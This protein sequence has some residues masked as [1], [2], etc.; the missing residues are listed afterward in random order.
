MTA[1]DPGTSTG[2]SGAWVRDRLGV[3]VRTTSS[4]VGLDLHDLVGLAVRRNP[5]R[6]H[7]LVS[8]VL[9]KHVPTDPRV[10]HGA[11]LLL[12]LLVRHA[13]AGD[14]LA[15]TARHHGDRL[16]AALADHD[17]A[18]AFRDAVVA[19]LDTDVPHGPPPVV[20]GYA[21][22]AVALGFSVAAA[23]P[24]STALHST[25]R[26]VVGY[27]AAGGFEEEHSHATSHLLLPADPDLLT[28]D[29]PRPLVL[30]DDELSTGTTVANTIAALHRLCPRDRYVVAA[31]VDLRGADDE[32]RLR[33]AVEGLG[34]RL[35]VVALARGE[36][37]LPAGVLERGAA[38]VEEV[39]G[40]A[41]AAP[42]A[43]SWTTAPREVPVVWP[44][45]Q[46]EGARHGLAWEQ[47]TGLE[48]AAAALATRIAVRGGEVHVLGTEEQ[49]AAPLLLGCALADAHPDV[50]V[51]YSTTTRSPALAVDDPGCALRT[52]LAFTGPEDGGARFAY[53]TPAAQQV[54]VVTDVPAAGP[55]LRGP[56]G[57]LAALSAQG[58][59]VDLVVLPAVAP[60]LPAPLHGPAFGSYA[61]DDVSWLLTDLSHAEL[62]APTADRER[63]IQSGRAHYAESLPIEFQPDDAY[64]ELFHTSVRE[65]SAR[66]AHAVGVVSEILLGERG[67]GIVLASLARAGTPIGVLV[68]RWCRRFHDLD[69]PH[70][71]VSIVR[72]RGIDALALR[73]L[74]THHDPADVVFVDGWTGKGAIARELT[75][76]LEVHHA[77]TGVR[78]DD[79]L[80]VLADPGGCVTVFGTR[81]DFLIPSACLNST[82]SGLVSRT[83][84]NDEL[85]GPGDF[86]GAKFYAELAGADVS[87][88]YLD[89]VTACFD[90]VHDDVVRDWPAVAAGD[91]TPTWAGWRAVEEISERY[92]IGQVNLVKPGVGET[93][94]VLL[95]RV[96]ERVL[97]RPGAAADLPHVLALAAARGVPVEEVAGLAYSCVGLI[98]PSAGGEG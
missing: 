30:V 69:V 28:T 88:T 14:T 71:A 68:R 87:G 56:D 25:R 86:H 20:L 11:G 39:G 72:G 90:D 75:A 91:R 95:R 3:D 26:Q 65:S 47:V 27:E 50:A 35:D 46:P 74:A 41:P 82:V 5:R 83:V 1:T 67:P 22:T 97:V 54:V 19:E 10:V 44:H 77:R 94:R 43:T 13:L 24:G 73:Y 64:Y 59:D 38:L 4:P 45:D 84:L 66:I 62:E 29:P 9:G 85:I 52:V 42:D 40:A 76:A 92:G 81:D 37:V 31:L 57:L 6:A 58:S 32:A 80:A 93:T 16:R 78:F 51:R 98:D 96:P 48:Q 21:E 23:L 34:A 55:A 12:G 70:H 63:E 36:V 15:P 53:N 79:S 61:A 18:V 89:A 2:W 33:T 60:S 49:M 8:R 7:L 17:A